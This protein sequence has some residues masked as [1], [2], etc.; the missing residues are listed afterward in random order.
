MC[1]LKFDE[2]IDFICVLDVDVIF[3]EMSRSY[4]DI[5]ES[6]EI[7]VYFLGIGLGVYDIYF[8]CIFIKEE[9]IVNI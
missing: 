3:I 9:I 2:I 6:F 7:V 1:Y 5:I 4:G 8:F